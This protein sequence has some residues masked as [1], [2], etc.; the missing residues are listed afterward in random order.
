MKEFP[1]LEAIPINTKHVVVLW[2]FP[3]MTRLVYYPKISTKLYSKSN[4]SELSPPFNIKRNK[5][6]KH[7]F[8]SLTENEVERMIIPRII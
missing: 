7:R 5:T 1:Y 6:R 8:F 4:Y 3:T 2:R